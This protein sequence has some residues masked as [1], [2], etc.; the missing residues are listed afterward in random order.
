VFASVYV[1]SLHDAKVTYNKAMRNQHLE[2]DI[3][4]HIEDLQVSSKVKDIRLE[5]SPSEEA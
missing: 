3:R 5:T 1:C 4:R 2:E